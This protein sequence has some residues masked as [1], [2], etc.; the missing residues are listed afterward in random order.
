MTAI[1]PNAQ[2]KSD[3]IHR[4]RHHITDVHDPTVEI[5]RLRFVLEEEP[6]VRDEKGLFHELLTEERA[7]YGIDCLF[8]R[9]NE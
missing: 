4:V 6:D 2:V 7:A 5:D 1:C 9:L 8:G 3:L